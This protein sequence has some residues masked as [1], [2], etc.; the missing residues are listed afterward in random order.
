MQSEK[1]RQYLFVAGVFRSGTSMLYACLNQHPAIALMYEPELQ[2]HDLPMH[3]FL[4]QN[5]LENANAWGKFL[6]R[7]GFPA[8]P[9]EAA[10][11]FHRPED[12]YNAYADRKNAFYGG[13]KSPMLH[14]Y[15]PR[16]VER[17]PNAKI[18]TISRNPTAVAS[19]IQEAAKT[20]KWFARGN[21]L[22]RALYGQE[23]MLQ[24]CIMLQ[25]K[26]YHILHLTYEAL[27]TDPEAECRRICHYLDLPYEHR[28]TSLE[29]ADLTPIADKPVHLKL[30]T[31]K[32]SA[33]ALVQPDLS[34]EW[35]EMLKAH[36]QRTL[37]SLDRLSS[38]KRPI[39]PLPSASEK[40]RRAIDKGRFLHYRTRWKRFIYHLLPAE[41]IRV[42]RATKVLIH[43]AQSIQ[44]EKYTPAE[45]IRIRLITGALILASITTGAALHTKSHGDISPLAFFIFPVLAAGWFFGWK[46]IIFF[47]LLGAAAWTLGPMLTYSPEISLLWVIWNLFSR[48]SVLC[49]LGLFAWHL[50]ATLLIH[51]NQK[52]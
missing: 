26:G 5:W 8:Y 50:K 52:D 38:N 31:G 35:L 19:S 32:I 48:G 10:K 39:E 15:L 27:T 16:L 44:A 9:K 13:E 6:F 30:H 22:E 41:F 51:Q 40:I 34:P 20:T 43:S 17:F 47:S 4:H 11:H 3:L 7:H 18:I 45:K 24:D 14:G 46:Q 36:W 37:K 25:N 42:F 28:M 12:F 49:I 23:K 21:M 1:N 2:S 33:S 29:N